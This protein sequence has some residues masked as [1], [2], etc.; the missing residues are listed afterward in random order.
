MVE[1]KLRE[2]GQSM[3]EQ[4]PF[5][6]KWYLNG[7]PKSGLHMITATIAPIAKPCVEDWDGAV[8]KRPWAGTFNFNSW[9]NE[10][11]PLEKVLYKVSR[12]Q[13]GQFLKAHTGYKS[14]IERFLWYSGISHVFIYR[15]PRD[16]AVSQSYHVVAEDDD[17]FSHPDKDMYRALGSHREVLKA[18]I[19]GMDKYPGV[20]ERWEEYAP[21]LEVDWVFKLRF[22][23]MRAHPMEVTRELLKYGLGRAAPIYDC[24]LTIVEDAF[25]VV[26][27]TMVANQDDHRF[28]PTFRKG[29]IGQWHY[30]FDQEITDLFKETDKNHW[31]EKLGYAES[32]EWLPYSVTNPAPCDPG[33]YCSNEVLGASCRGT[34]PDCKYGYVYDEEEMGVGG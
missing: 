14:E 28:S 29:H 9:T 20:M 18:V 2:D 34:H 6:A 16:V 5:Q 25:D 24:R 19:V 30:E 21:W 11:V 4:H 32:D 3:I 10:W 27:A 26:V 23:D 33:G 8:W 13:D 17:R 1:T 12:L 31:V 7:F 15:D 22:E